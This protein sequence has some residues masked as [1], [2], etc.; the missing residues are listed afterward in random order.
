MVRTTRTRDR[1]LRYTDIEPQQAQFVRVTGVAGTDTPVTELELYAADVDTFENDPVFGV[2]RGWTDALN[3]TTTD[4]DLGGFESR[5]SLRLFDN[6]TDQ[7]AKITKP[8]PD[9]TRQVT[10]FELGSS[11][12]NY[13]GQF[14]FDVLGRSGDSR[15]VRWHFLLTPG[16]YPAP[17]STGTPAKPTL[18]AWNGSRWLLVGTLDQ[19]IE[20]HT[21][22][23]VTVDATPATA[24]VTI[25]GQTF[26][27]STTY[28]PATALAG[29]AFTS[30]GTGVTS[31][32]W[33]LDDVRIG[34][35]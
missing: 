19:L 5:R 8:A 29:V 35:R 1:A 28:Q 11:E 18:Q 26:T 7:V 15:T 9:R 34:D 13:R 3:A 30:A 25:G 22:R 16:A 24:T 23:T 2:P 17:G 33:F 12:W 4:V 21:W 31:T 20:P 32:T 10:T 27:T 14:V 6:Y